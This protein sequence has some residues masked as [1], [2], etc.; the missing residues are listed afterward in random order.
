VRD[1][2]CG[3]RLCGQEISKCRLDAARESSAASLRFTYVHVRIDV[4][5]CFVML[6][7]YYQV[8][9]LFAKRAEGLS[10]LS[11]AAAGTRVGSR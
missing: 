2:L 11:L 6:I 9:V 5:V 7:S 4:A 1:M 3:Y 10:V 8:Q